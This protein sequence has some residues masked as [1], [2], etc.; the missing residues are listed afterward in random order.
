MTLDAL[1]RPHVGLVAAVVVV[2]EKSVEMSVVSGAAHGG[3]VG[4]SR[5]PI[6]VPVPLRTCPSTYF[7]EVDYCGWAGRNF[8]WP[9]LGPSAT[10]D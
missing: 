3:F 8:L 7:R 6:P 9:R 4:N 2:V 1:E 5:V 10:Q